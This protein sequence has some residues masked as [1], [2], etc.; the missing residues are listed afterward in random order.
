MKKIDKLDSVIRGTHK[1]TYRCAQS[2][3]LLH[4]VVHKYDTVHAI[5]QAF[6][7][8]ETQPLKLRLLICLLYDSGTRISEILRVKGTDINAHLQIHIS[9]SKGSNDR[10]ISAS[11]FNDY[12]LRKRGKDIYLFEGYSRFYVYRILVKLNIFISKQ[13]DINN[14]VTHIFRYLYINDLQ[15]IVGNDIEIGKLIGHKSKKS[16]DSYTNEKTNKQR[17]L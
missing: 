6:I 2:A 17:R 14:K 16:I 4:P 11:K 8:N 1:A 3:I 12:L 7:S 10:I 15:S 13:G 9:G 5:I